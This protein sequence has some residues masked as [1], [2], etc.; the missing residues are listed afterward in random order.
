M[1]VTPRTLQLLDDV[2]TAVDRVVDAQV[3]DLVAAWADAWDEVAPDLT[4]TLLEML[5]AGD[6]VTRAQ[7]LRSQRLR[8]ALAIIAAELERLAEEAGVRITGDLAAVIELAGAAQASVLDSQLPAGFITSE[9]FAAWSRVDAGQIAAI[10]ART[11]EQITSRTADLSTEAYQVVR[12]E[13][14]RGVAAGSSPRET[15]RRMVQRAESGFNGGLTRA[16]VIARTETLDAHRAAAQLSQEQHADVLA[17]WVWLCK[18]DTRS[19]PSCW[20]QH[21]QLHDLDE[22]GPIDHHQGRCARMP[23]TKSW[24]ELGFDR[25]PEPEDLTPDAEQ[26]F[27][28]LTAAEQL[29][30]LGPKRYAAWLAG[31]YPMGS[32]SVRR[33]SDG[34]RDAFHVSPVPSGGRRSRS[35]A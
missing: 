23:K 2:R 34:W 9:D 24:A 35:A 15:A 12:R 32:W 4:A 31:D 20:D 11:T 1:P 22:P 28:A 13:L 10:V 8:R 3:R 16:L 21:G 29:S 26:R 14:I 5:V 33:S 25:V 30:I 17:G 18:L 27:L 19:C 7:L 6:R